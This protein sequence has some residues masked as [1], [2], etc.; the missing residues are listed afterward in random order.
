V[1]HPAIAAA[2]PPT[3]RARI[4]SVAVPATAAM[5]LGAWLD[6][7]ALWVV[8]VLLAVAVGA[9]TLGCLDGLDP[10]GVPVEATF[11]PVAAAFGGLGAVHLAGTSPVALGALAAGGLLVAAAV[12]AE[13]AWLRTARRADV[14]IA[15]VVVFLG[16]I[17]GLGMAARG[18][19]AALPASGSPA[20]PGSAELV[21][22]VVGVALVAGLVGYRLRAGDTTT[23]AATL[24]SATAYAL[25]AGAGIA[26]LR[27]G[28]V[29][30]LAWPG[31]LTAVVYAW[32]LYQAGVAGLDLARQR[33]LDLLVAGGMVAIAAVVHL[34]SA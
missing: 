29:P 14:A 4:S 21:V 25:V 24:W 8:A 20:A 10:R 12:A 3:E 16:V 11:L 2:A 17:G 9:A 13:R 15:I 6:G 27:G 22:A 18:F 5:A 23:V 7:P 26:V 1:T 34:G 31:A 30:V 28:H 33:V 32:S 19:V